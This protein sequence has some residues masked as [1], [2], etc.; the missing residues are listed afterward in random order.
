MAVL[1]HAPSGVRHPLV[2]RT[3]VGRSR[4]C[5]L[6]LASQQVSSVHAELTWDGERWL[7][8]DLG[9]RNG[10]HLDG[11]R[12]RAEAR[13]PL[14]AG[15]E[16][17]FGT[18]GER[19]VLV[20]ASPPGLVAIADDG[21]V[22]QARAGLLC[23]PSED[24]PEVT[25]L[26]HLDGRWRLETEQGARPLAAQEQLTAGGVGWRIH[27]PGPVQHTDEGGEAPMSVAVIL[28]ELQVSRDEEHVVMRVHHEG[29]SIELR[30]RAHDFFLLTLARA[31]LADQAE[32]GLAE[33]E[34]GW[35]YRQDL[36]R[37]LQVDRNLLNLWIY[38]ARRQL[39]DAGVLEVGSLIERRTSAEQLRL[40]IARLRVLSS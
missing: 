39:A 11:R 4:S 17:V 12:L 26:E 3:L 6:R 23:L 15:S 18:G 8:H 9:S 7:L 22:V 25:L 33:A 40:G 5:E 34:H 24:E 31:R 20:D 30:P 21:R 29:R 38:R 1:E 2:S 35:V 10:T 36:A 32:P 37:S 16:V 13:E 28:L 27:P 19:F 14:V